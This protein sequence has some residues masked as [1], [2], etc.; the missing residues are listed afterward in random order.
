MT[1]PQLPQFLREVVPTNPILDWGMV[2][3]YH[4]QIASAPTGLNNLVFNP[5]LANLADLTAA[6]PDFIP[7]HYFA[8]PDHIFGVN[9]Q[10]P[11]KSSKPN[12]S[13][14]ATTTRSASRLRR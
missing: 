7:P 9:V 6:H 14:S 2:C 12:W 5:S 13:R 8:G 11:S 1:T 3:R 10:N 4:D